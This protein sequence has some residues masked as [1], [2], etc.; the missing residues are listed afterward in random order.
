MHF[1]FV[2]LSDVFP[3]F[4][5]PVIQKTVENQVWLGVSDLWSSQLYYAMTS[6]VF[7][8]YNKLCN[9]LYIRLSSNSQ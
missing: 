8:V 6:T 3:T 7:V 1:Y 9:M 4:R 5:L 2:K